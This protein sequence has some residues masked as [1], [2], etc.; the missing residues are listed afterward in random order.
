MGGRDLLI[1]AGFV[2]VQVLGQGYA[3]LSTRALQQLPVHL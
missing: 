3:A 1:P 2:D